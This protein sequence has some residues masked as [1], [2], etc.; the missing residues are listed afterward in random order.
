MISGG[1]RCPLYDD[2]AVTTTDLRSDQ[3][4]HQLDSAKTTEP[5]HISINVTVP[6]RVGRGV[7]EDQ[8]VCALAGV[9]LAQRAHLGT[10][11]LIEM[12]S[13]SVVFGDMAIEQS[14]AS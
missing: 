10:V 9:G 4:T 5:L 3:A 7:L 6:S 8:R 14:G 2:A 1:Y 13:G 11:T 12:C